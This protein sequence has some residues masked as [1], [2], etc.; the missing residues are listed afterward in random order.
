MSVKIA[1][2]PGHG[3]HDTGADGPQ[4]LEEANTVLSISLLL[5]DKLSDLGFEVMLTRE[6]D[7]FI[8]LGDRCSLANEWGADYF[9]SVHLNSNGQTAVGI[10]TLFTSDTGEEFA[11]PIQN[12]LIEATGDTDRGLKERNDLYV[13]NGTEMPAILLEL[14]FISHPGTEEK[15]GTT[16]Y[17]Q[18]LVDAVA[19]GIQEYLV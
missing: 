14:G 1:I 12:A 5:A 13:L 2:D 4:G 8:E 7:V 17:K 19:A 9:V 11:A 10:E 16:E 15:L 3:G 18:L 6:T